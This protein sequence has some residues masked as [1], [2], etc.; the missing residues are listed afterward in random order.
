MY[1]GWQPS[2]ISDPN[3]NYFV[4]NHPMIVRVQFGLNYNCSFLEIYIYIYHD[5][6]RSWSN[7]MTFVTYLILRTPDWVSRMAYAIKNGLYSTSIPRILNNPKIKY[8]I[9]KLKESWNWKLDETSNKYNT[10]TLRIICDFGDKF[11][12]LMVK[13]TL[14]ILCQLRFEA[15]SS[16]YSS[17]LTQI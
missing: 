16:E 2:W 8:K 5:H 17:F 10:T 13:C 6:L 11:T 14:Y 12:S 3:K 1:L 9:F 7:M 15:F 4:L